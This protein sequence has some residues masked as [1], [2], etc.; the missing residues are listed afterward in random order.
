MESYTK[1]G[2]E[3]PQCGRDIVILIVDRKF[4]KQVPMCPKCF[5]LIDIRIEKN[6][7]KRE[8]SLLGK[9]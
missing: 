6:S 8:D 9:E 1:M 7:E 5:S 2:F 4:I 3:C